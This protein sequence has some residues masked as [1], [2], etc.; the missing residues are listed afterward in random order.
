[1]G[2]SFSR[3]F[4]LRA[5]IAAVTTC[6]VLLGAFRRVPYTFRLMDR[7]PLSGIFVVTALEFAVTVV[8]VVVWRLAGPQ[9]AET[10]A[11]RA[12]RLLR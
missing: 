12:G 9:V 4:T 7:D 1:M 5:V 11:A 6:C 3:N 8:V 10:A 2:Q